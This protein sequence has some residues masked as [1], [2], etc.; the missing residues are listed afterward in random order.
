[1]TQR[2]LPEP[3]SM[4]SPALAFLVT[5]VPEMGAVTE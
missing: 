4:L 1:M 5:T 2:V 3:P